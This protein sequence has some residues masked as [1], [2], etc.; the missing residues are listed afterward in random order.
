MRT[1]YRQMLNEAIAAREKGYQYAVGMTNVP[2]L[3]TKSMTGAVKIASEIYTQERM[4]YHAPIDLHIAA[5]ERID[6]SP[7]KYKTKGAI[8][9]L[10]QLIGQD[11][12]VAGYAGRTFNGERTL[13]FDGEIQLDYIRVNDRVF[14]RQ[15]YGTSREYTAY[16]GNVV[17]D[18]EVTETQVMYIRD[19][20]LEEV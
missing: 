7:V 11:K 19:V 20:Q 12:R 9:I 2:V 18:Q 16:M 4:A 8:P 1:E 5:F 13:V 14:L 3:F 6:N 10:V 15:T 17:A